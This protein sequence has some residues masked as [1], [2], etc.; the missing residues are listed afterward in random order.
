[1]RVTNQY[2][3]QYRER[4]QRQPPVD[5]Q[6]HD[7]HD[8]EG[9]EVVD[10]GQN[11]GGEHFIDGVHVGRQPGDQPPHRMGIEEG[12]VKLLHVAEDVAAK[13]EHDLLPDPLHEIRLNEFEQVLQTEDGDIDFGQL[14]DSVPW[15]GRQPPPDP[16]GRSAGLVH[17]VQVD[18]DFHQVG[19]GHVGQRLESDRNRGDRRLQPVGL[20]IMSQ[21][22]DQDRIVDLA[23]GV[24]ILLADLRLGPLRLHCGR[25]G[26]FLRPP[27]LLRVELIRLCLGFFRHR[28]RGGSSFPIVGADLRIGRNPAAKRMILT[29]RR[30]TLW[31][32]CTSRI[33][34]RGSSS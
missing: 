22:P 21:P 1:M 32:E 8:A 2:H 19:A 16:G 26:G 11:A 9:E 4:Q 28:P 10:D 33:P 23:Y 27:V 30:M 15:V 6:H 24:F 31:S 29:A 12:H 17:H 20:Q 34:L 5:A 18:A 13:I 14:G 3:R 7:A 25:R